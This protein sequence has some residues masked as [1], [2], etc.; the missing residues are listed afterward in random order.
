MNRLPCFLRPCCVLG[1]LLGLLLGAPALQKAYA[2][3]ASSGLAGP[4]RDATTATVRTMMEGS[5]PGPASVQDRFD[6]FS[7]EFA[8]DFGVVEGLGVMGRDANFVERV[9]RTLERK[10]GDTRVYGWLETSLLLYARMRAY[11]EL[12]RKGFDVEVEMDDMAEGKLGVR[13]ARSLE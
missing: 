13:V 1:T 6:A 3:T 11:T 8:R 7:R 10:I 12:E 9:R 5:H 4:T 2:Q